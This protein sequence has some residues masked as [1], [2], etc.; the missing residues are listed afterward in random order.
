M[1]SPPSNPIP[2]PLCRGARVRMSPLGRRRHP[3]Y[4]ERQGVIVG[5]AGGRLVYVHQAA[6]VYK[7]AA[8]ATPN[9][10]PE[11]REHEAG[12]EDEEE[13]SQAS[14]AAAVGVSKHSQSATASLSK[15]VSS[16]RWFGQKARSEIVDSS[17]RVKVS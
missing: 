8:P 17:H 6:L 11:G 12:E 1:S 5:H 16:L 9:A 13:L 4:G 7:P 2:Q 14:D 10:A 3:S 15:A